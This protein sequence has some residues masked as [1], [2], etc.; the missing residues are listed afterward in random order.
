MFRNMKNPIKTVF[1]RPLLLKKYPVFMR[2][3]LEN[4]F[5][6]FSWLLLKT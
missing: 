1:W 6:T 3:T 2:K 5:K 4:G